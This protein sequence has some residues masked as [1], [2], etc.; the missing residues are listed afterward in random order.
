MWSGP[1]SNI[2]Q[3]LLFLLFCSLYLILLCSLNHLSSFHVPSV[4]FLCTFHVPV[5]CSFGSSDMQHISIKYKDSRI[6]YIS[7]VRIS[8]T[9]MSCPS[10][11][12]LN[13]DCL[14]LI[15]FLLPTPT[16]A[17][18]NPRPE[19]PGSVFPRTRGPEIRVKYLDSDRREE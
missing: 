3:F 7:A 5:P 2:S 1:A 8:P 16:P 17:L 10:Y 14:A 4:Y 15:C 9:T 12:T 13:K 19:F 11:S 18:S 6:M